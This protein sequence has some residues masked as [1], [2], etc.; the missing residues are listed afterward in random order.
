MSHSDIQMIYLASKS[1]RRQELLNQIGIRFIVLD[2]PAQDSAN[3]DMVDET[4]LANE[5]AAD[6]VNRLSRDKAE[7]AWQYL[8]SHDI[9]KHP[10]LTAD[11]TVVLDNLI[12][13]KP[14]NKVEALE[15]MERLSGKTHQV[16]TSVAIKNG[17]FFSQLLQTS[18]VTFAALSSDTIEAY[19]H[20]SEPYDKAGGYGIQGLAGKF[21]KHIEGSYSGIMGLPLYETSE[22][23]RKA[24]IVVP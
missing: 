3:A 20:T 8:I 5:N 22:L 9:V 15:M 17:D 24:G 16:L 11:T 10:V 19:I 21:I 23:L 1:P 6:Y 13:G 18:C 2:V 7:C 12:L 4:V 14:Q